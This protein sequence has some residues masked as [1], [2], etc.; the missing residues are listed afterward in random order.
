MTGTRPLYSP[1]M[2]RLLER[3]ALAA[4]MVT[5]PA[6][7]PNGSTF[8]LQVLCAAAGAFVFVLILLA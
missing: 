3:H 2:A 5:A 7:A 8:A 1:K 4:R 6:N